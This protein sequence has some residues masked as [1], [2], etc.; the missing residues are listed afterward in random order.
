MLGSPVIDFGRILLTNLPNENDVSKLEEF[1]RNILEIYLKTLRN[2]YTMAN[3][4]HVTR[5]Y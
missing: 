2:V 5:H 3:I 1:C 4:M